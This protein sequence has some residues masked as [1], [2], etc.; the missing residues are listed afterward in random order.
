VPSEDRDPEYKEL[1]SFLVDV[2]DGGKPKSDIE[3]G[4]QDSIAVM[5]SNYCMQEQRKVY[6]SEI[7][8]MG[9][10]GVELSGAAKSKD[11]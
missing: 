5:L 9:K 8:E 4:L 6:F 7:D 2:R 3:V 1:H 10:N 11:A